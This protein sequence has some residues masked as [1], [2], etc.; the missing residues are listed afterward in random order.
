MTSDW[1]PAGRPRVRRDYHNAH[2]RNRD[3]YDLAPESAIVE[4]GVREVFTPYQPV[5]P[6]EEL[7]GRSSEI[8]KLVEVLNTPGQHALL[9][10]DRGVGKSS[11]AN[12]V[13]HTIKQAALRDYFVKRCDHTDT[14]ETIFKDPLAAAG[15]DVMRVEY[16][17]QEATTRKGEI[18]LHTLAGGRER[19]TASS[20]TY[21]P[22]GT[23]GASDA[24]RHLADLPA[25]MLVDELDVVR[26]P[27]ARH[28]IAEL[29]THLSDQSSSFKLLLV[30]VAETATDLTDAHASVQRRL[31]E[32]ELQ[33]MAE[34]NLRDIV[35]Q[36]AQKLRLTFD[37]DVMT[38]IARLS[39]GYAHFTH[40][41]ALKCAENAIRT[42][43]SRIERSD[44]PLA[45]TT[46]VEDAEGTL[47][48]SYYASVR[49]QTEAYREV[50]SAAAALDGVEFTTRQLRQAMPTL[51]SPTGPL[52]RLV[53]DD[54][55]SILRRTAKGVYRFSD[56]RMRS[57]IR[58]IHLMLDPIG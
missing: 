49:A 51:S 5:Q 45:M 11:L 33:L 28:K 57:Y 40:L 48:Q 6:G 19:Q 46:A 43:R 56:P 8:R 16:V 9:Y 26:D 1:R 27:T 50:L 12:V 29:I 41:L 39:A 36:G 47:R 7:T 24:A 34:D 17:Q 23:I 38:T 22:D 58:I 25:F 55:T 52:R 37:G 54:G 42:G 44:L 30:G 21:R 20:T 15:V 18:K 53:S 2:I 14:F 35:A 4:A 3:F 32:T 10:G 31:R 13:S